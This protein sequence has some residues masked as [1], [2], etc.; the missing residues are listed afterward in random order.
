MEVYL[1]KDGKVIKKNL[2][3]AP[4]QYNDFLKDGFEPVDVSFKYDKN[5]KIVL[6]ENRKPIQVVTKLTKEK[7]KEQ[8]EYFNKLM[9]NKKRSIEIKPDVS[10]E[11]FSKKECET[12]LAEMENIFDDKLNLMEKAFDD[13]LDLSKK[14]FDD[15]I[16]LLEKK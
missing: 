1:R 6:D 10:R 11:T 4:Q 7:S 12:M 2:D 14:A 15:M 8:E 3:Y 16:N 13:K 5:E 9:I